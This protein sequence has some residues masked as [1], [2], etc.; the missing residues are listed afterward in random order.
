MK[1]NIFL[2]FFW[3]ISACAPNAGLGIVTITPAPASPTTAELAAPEA[4]V[5]PLINPTATPQPEP[6]I[7]PAAGSLTEYKMDVEMDYDAKTVAVQQTILYTNNTGQPLNEIVLAVVPNLWPNTFQMQGISLF[8]Q[9]NPEY[10]LTG[11]KMTV[12]LPQSLAPQAS[13]ELG[14][15]YSLIMPAH[16]ANPDPNLVRPQI[17]GYTANQ[18]NLVN[19]YP[20]I[21]PFDENGWVLHDP[22]YYGEH[23]VYD[24]ANFDITLH[25]INTQNPP[26]VASSGEQEL[27]ENGM[28]LWG[29]QLR[30]F[31]IS[32][33]REFI[34]AENYIVNDDVTIKSYYFPLYENAGKA[35][36]D[37]TVKAYLTYSELFG[38]YKHKTLSAVQGDFNDG[39]E[40]D[41]LYFLSNGFYNLYDGTEK[42]Y[43]VLVAAHETCHM[44][45]FGGV[46]NDQAEEPWLDESL[47]TYCEKL[48]YQQ[49]YPDSLRW[50][51]DVRINFYQPD[52]LVDTRL[53]DSGG[54][55]PYTN[56]VYRRGALFLD[57]LYERMSAYQFNIFIKNY[58]AEM[59]GKRATREDFFRILAE[60][61]TADI[62]DLMAKYM[63]AN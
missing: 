31:A 26:V 60:Y 38:P 50:W 42:N 59:E 16:E 21:V 34:V 39:M 9:L 63:G 20:F 53:Y 5:F 32:A 7:K 37:N 61:N 54:F 57:D 48:F 4:T 6:L 55:T 56:A 62:A 2:F 36:L 10:E 28:R 14:L 30:T 58:Y 49:H 24:Q 47:S 29:S 25:F 15:A 45:W 13:L 27:N 23:L 19:W 11:Q 44:W 46:A 35:V 51:W 8:N 17:F 1:K 12:F 40:F 43:L 33:S 22:W 52:G 18:L 3:M 41:G